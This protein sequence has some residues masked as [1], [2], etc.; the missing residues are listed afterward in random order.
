[1]KAY[2][3]EKTTPLASKVPSR[4][5]VSTMSGHIKKDF[6]GEEVFG[7]KEWMEAHHL[8]WENGTPLWAG[9]INVYFVDEQWM[10]DLPDEGSSAQ[11]VRMVDRSEVRPSDTILEHGLCRTICAADIKHSAGVGVT[12]RGSSYH[13]G[14]LPVLRVSQHLTDDLRKIIEDI[15]IS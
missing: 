2:W 8:E 7:V 12:I 3:K 14:C 4:I 10:Q 15:C 5:T 13:S 9:K 6:R 11:I 1:M